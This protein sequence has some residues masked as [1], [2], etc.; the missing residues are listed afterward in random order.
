MNAGHQCFTEATADSTGTPESAL[1]KDSEPEAAAP[2][3]TAADAVYMT[4]TLTAGVLL[5]ISV[6]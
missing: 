5:L 4:A 3:M 1:A 6:F 2:R